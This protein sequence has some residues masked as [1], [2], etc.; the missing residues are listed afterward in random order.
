MLEL[1][2]LASMETY[3]EEVIDLVHG[4]ELLHFFRIH[5]AA[6]Q[7]VEPFARNI[8]VITRIK[9]GATQVAIEWGVFGAPPFFDARVV[10]GVTAGKVANFAVD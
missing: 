9:E 2:L 8:C 1:N 3:L 4:I 7:S 10:A 6:S 5:L